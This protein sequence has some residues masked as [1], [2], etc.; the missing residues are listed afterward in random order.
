MS[1]PLSRFT[2]ASEAPSFVTALWPGRF[3][4]GLALGRQRPVESPRALLASESVVS[5]TATKPSVA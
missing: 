3:E 4:L 1:V 2:S 5:F